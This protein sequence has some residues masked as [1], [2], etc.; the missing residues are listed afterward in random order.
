VGGCVEG[1]REGRTLA[2]TAHRER[3]R[4]VMSFILVGWLVGGWW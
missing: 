4:K 3:V 2:R 1:R